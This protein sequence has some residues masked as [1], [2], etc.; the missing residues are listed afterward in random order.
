LNASE[1]ISEYDLIR[2]HIDSQI[3]RSSSTSGKKTSS[4]FSNRLF[5]ALMNTTLQQFAATS[6]IFY[7]LTSFLSF[8][9]FDNIDS[10][11]SIISII[12]TIISMLAILPTFYLIERLGRKPLRVWGGLLLTISHALLFSGIVTNSSGFKTSSVAGAWIGIIGMYLFNMVFSCTWGNVVTTYQSEIFP[13][14]LRTKG[15]AICNI[16]NWILY[17]LLRTLAAPALYKA[18]TSRPA[19]YAIFV[20]VGVVMFGW[21]WFELKETRGKSLEEMD[22]VFELPESI[23]SSSKGSA[24]PGGVWRG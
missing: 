17:F 18:L 7:N 15:Y 9:G 2:S 4:S 14:L 13:Q 23:G 22:E 20:A 12:T 21:T 5:I 16:W 6:I 10:N 11:G 24:Y 8:A 3:Q 1:V 19:F